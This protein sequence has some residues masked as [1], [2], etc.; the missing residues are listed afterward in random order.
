MELVV[1]FGGLCICNIEIVVVTLFCYDHLFKNF[2]GGTPLGFV[3]CALRL[4]YILF[5]NGCGGLTL[6]VLELFYS[7]LWGYGLHYLCI[8]LGPYPTL[9]NSPH[10]SHAHKRP[11][12]LHMYNSPL[13]TLRAKRTCETNTHHESHE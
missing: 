12:S 5:C 11:P 6:C 1:F 10:I 2:L 13:T 8:F 7:Q 3:Y 4:S 9:F